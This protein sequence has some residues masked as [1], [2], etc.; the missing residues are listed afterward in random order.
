[1]SITDAQCVR[2]LVNYLASGCQHCVYSIIHN[3]RS[4]SIRGDGSC[5]EN[6]QA[7][8]Y[9]L[10]ATEFGGDCAAAPEYWTK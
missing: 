6:T 1:M 7:T 3:N 5:F 9:M 4:A 2:C 10:D 8:K